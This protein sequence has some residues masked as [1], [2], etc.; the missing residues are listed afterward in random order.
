MSDRVRVG[1]R[2]AVGAVAFAAAA[3]C[4]VSAV[5]DPAGADAPTFETKHSEKEQELRGV[6]DTIR[7]SEEQ[8]R[9]IEAEIESIRSDQ[10]RLTDALIAT[11]G[12]V[13]DA[14][15]EVAFAADRLAAVEARASAIAG[16]LQAR[17]GVI[18]EILAAIQRIGSNPAPAILVRS[19]DM[20][21]AIRAATLLIAMTQT[22]KADV[23]AL[24]RNIEELKSARA[25]IVQ[26]RE[27]S[28]QS[29]AAL[30][31]EKQRLSALIDAR[32]ASM[33]SAEAALNSEQKRAAELAGQA[34][35]LRE[36][37]SSIEAEE[38]KRKVQ[39]QAAREADAQAARAI[40]AKAE[41]AQD[42]RP[43]PLRTDVAFSDV[44]GRLRLPVAG[45]I[46]KPFGSPDGIGGMA[47]GILVGT[48]AGAVVS[49]PAD[50]TVL[51]SGPFRSYGR[52]LI[53][54]VGEGYYLLLAGL[55]QTYVA[56]GSAVLSGEPVGLVGDGSSKMATAVSVGAAQPLLYIELR[57][58][59]TAIDPRPWW[60]KTDIEKAHG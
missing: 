14:E 52:L 42:V 43:A 13:Q 11:T 7:A 30:A 2:Y 18:A 35:T 60:A 26:Q 10:A 21:E 27:E 59:G 3:G 51:F 1:M 22:L 5:A 20:A 6:E 24:A 16:S 12:R 25:S 54:D 38:G 39:E 41:K 50:G 44:K 53:I 56:R 49:S 8:R 34:A 32:K 46:L 15:R 55:E 57:K 17:R 37:L 4:A 23:E 28:K 19:G 47:H 48:L 58:D 9:T 31:V 33:S 45:T 40:E 36:L 29:A